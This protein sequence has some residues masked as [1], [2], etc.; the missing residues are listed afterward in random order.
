MEV[1]STSLDNDYIY[2]TNTACDFISLKLNDHYYR[3]L[4]FTD[5]YITDSI[6]TDIIIHAEAVCFKVMSVIIMSDRV[7][8]RN[9]VYEIS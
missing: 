4:L 5:R 8:S 9:S 7:K 2:L 6:F 1:D 3:T